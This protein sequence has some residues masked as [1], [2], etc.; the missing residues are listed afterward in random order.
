MAS[1][2]SG[3]TYA[4]ALKYVETLL[5]G[6]VSAENNRLKQ[7]LAITFT[8]KASSEMKDR[9]LYFL[10]KIA[11]GTYAD[12][13]EK[14]NILG[15]IGR[16]EAEASRSA[17]LMLDIIIRHYD[18]FQV[19]TIDSFINSVLIG[20]ALK[21]GLSSGFVIEDHPDDYVSYALD[22]VI[23]DINTDGETARVFD[24]FV[25]S[26]LILEGREE[27]LVRK[28]LAKLLTSMVLMLNTYGM[29][30]KKSVHGGR[31]FEERK[32]VFNNMKK[33]QTLLPEGRDKR[34]SNTLDKFILEN[35][36]NFRI[37]D[38]SSYFTKEHPPLNKNCEE[39]PGL[40][41]LWNAVRSGLK[42]LCELETFTRL[43]HYID[44]YKKV[45]VVFAETTREKDVLFLS[46]LNRI[47]FGLF[48][49]GKITMDEL[50]YRMAAKYRYLLIDEFQDTSMLQWSNFEQ[51]AREA[52]STGG[53]FFYVGDK[54][55]AIYRF[56]G[57]ESGLFDGVSEMLGSYGVE[58]S[59][60]STNYRSQKEIV[61]FNNTVF[62]KK[63]LEAFIK[64]Y[65]MDDEKGG[66]LLFG[67]DELKSVLSVFEAHRQECLKEKDSGYVK[68]ASIPGADKEERDEAVRGEMLAAVKDIIRRRGAGAAAVLVRSHDEAE[69]V[70]GWLLEEGIP[71]ESERTLK[72]TENFLIKEL[73]SFLKFLSNPIDDL[74]FSAFIMGDIFVKRTGME[75][76]R[77]ED[78]LFSLRKDNLNKEAKQYAYRA[79][80][81]KYADIWAK[82]MSDFFKKAGTVP[83]YEFIVSIV[84]RFEMLKHFPGQQAFIMKFLELV[85]KRENEQGS[86]GMFIEYME[87]A[88]GKDIFLKSENTDAV[89]VVTMHQAKGLEFDAVII[90][91][92]RI[93]I[94]IGSNFSSKNKLNGMKYVTLRS[95]DGLSLAYLNKKYNKFSGTLKKIYTG[96]FRKTL[97][98]ELNVLYVALTRAKDELYIFVPEGGKE[99]NP[100]S[101]LLPDIPFESGEKG[102]KKPGLKEA[103]LKMEIVPSEKADWL[104]LITD[105]FVKTDDIM[106]RRSIFSGEVYHYALSAIGNLAGKDAEAAV[107]NA[108]RAVEAEY[109]A[110]GNTEKYRDAVMRLVSA[111]PLKRFFY[112]ERGS[113]YNE[114]E[115]VDSLGNTKRIDRLIVTP[116]EI[117]II[118][119]K[120]SAEESFSDKNKEQVM[121]YKNIVG[122]IYPG[123]KVSGYLVYIDRADAKEV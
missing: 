26:Y 49:E 42:E 37:E 39:P 45:S 118:D 117:I 4:L 72:I 104:R 76:R 51:I 35:D 58:R 40:T 114:K 96:E 19:Q 73:I 6:G 65:C 54:K 43:N 74:S 36:E 5:K 55:Q 57:G 20:F 69:T 81:E 111:G 101:R 109:P 79:F 85:K 82:F 17:A 102:K 80:R 9:I 71:V 47:A 22:L 66:N 90:P 110:A 113:V 105:E 67:E 13:K 8:R 61:E 98:D 28:D 62:S 121:Q 116:E 25:R 50:Y 112:V 27:W 24:D 75:R 60:L 38:V 115:V 34:F 108:F 21:L 94:R 63:N 48:R 68:A 77:T 41:K 31:F 87:D 15:R 88:P 11:L 123:K 32:D 2:G 12:K 18:F 29:D 1:A 78:F 52:L 107:K 64:S 59:T 120:S 44:I 91:F 103:G 33:L 106:N 84:N 7:I 23:E 30:F 83:L 119:Y 56:R 53:E 89:K 3:K 100:A 14:D 95:E 93:N 16:P 99:M 122:E 70:S 92:F 46:E 97:I 10:K 86:I